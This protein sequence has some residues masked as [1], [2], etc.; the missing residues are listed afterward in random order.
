MWW[1]VVAISLT[2]SETTK[3]QWVYIQKQHID[4]FDHLV[5]VELNQI[6]QSPSAKIIRSDHDPNFFLEY[7]DCWL[8]EP[9]VIEDSYAVTKATPFQCRIRD[10]TYSAPIYVSLRYTR[11]R[12]IVLKKGV[13]IGRMP[14]MLR[15]QK[16][17]LH[18]K[19]E[20]E[21]AQLKECPRHPGG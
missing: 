9:T 21:L 10:C 12:Q 15:S 11:G 7:T 2:V 13:E 6:V 14:I 5:N 20:R 1:G 17:I 19:T 3:R 8:G 16:C 4:S 18:G